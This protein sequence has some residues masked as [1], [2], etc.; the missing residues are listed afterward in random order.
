MHDESAKGWSKAG[1]P[2]RNASAGGAPPGGAAAASARASASPWT[3]YLFLTPTMASLL[4][5]CFMPIA[6]GVWLSF[7]SGEPAGSARPAMGLMHYEYV[8][9]VHFYERP[10]GIPSCSRR[11]ASPV[12]ME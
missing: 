9:V 3:P 2:G 7:Q 10:M 11:A 5:I 6:F 4:L 12:P 1:D 8:L